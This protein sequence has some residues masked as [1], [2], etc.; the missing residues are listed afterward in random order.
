MQ[1]QTIEERTGLDR[2]T[3][4]Y[5]EREG[6]ICPQRL[7]NGY[8][9][10]SQK[11]IDDLMK[12]K[13]LRQ[14]GLSLDAI[15]HLIEGKEDLRHIL[16]SQLVILNA[17]KNHIDA[18]EAIC[19]MIMQD[20]VT[21]QTLDPNKYLCAWDKNQHKENIIIDVPG[22]DDTYYESHP[23]RR[24]IGRYIDQIFL[25]SILMV[26][27]VVVL[28]IRPFGSTQIRILSIG[29]L[30]LFMPFNALFLCLFGTTPGKFA[31]GIKV[32]TPEGNNPSFICALQREWSVFHYGCGFYIPIY[33]WV[34]MI[35]SYIMHTNGQ[36]LDWD[37]ETDMVY[38]QRGT[39]QRVYCSILCLICVFTIIFSSIDAQFPK[40]RNADLTISQFAENCNVYAKQ[41]DSAIRLSPEGEWTS[42]NSSPVLDYDV[43]TEEDPWN[44]EIVESWCFETDENNC[45]ANIKYNTNSQFFLGEKF[46][47]IL[48]TVIMSQPNAKIKT[49]KEAM[50][51][52]VLPVLNFDHREHYNFDGVIVNFKR[53]ASVENMEQDMVYIEIIVP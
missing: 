49:A 3:I 33:S 24:F 5:Y 41:N 20:N 31:V 27:L 15:Q 50:Q 2:A 12:I 9:D 10:Y 37:Y 47:L 39:G 48:Y 35:K 34:R 14:L 11:E 43:I 36:E 38:T 30:F 7:Q 16:D 19:K 51:Q 32:K 1:I 29:S 4:R 52:F 18:A 40:Y 21:Y 13:L 28:R 23:F 17:H 44:T 45:I 25:H 46:D 42:A 26:L 53:E 22:T 8:R 6:L